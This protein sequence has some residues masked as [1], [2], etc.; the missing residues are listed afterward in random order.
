MKDAAHWSLALLDRRVGQDFPSHPFP[1][2]GQGRMLQVRGCGSSDDFDA[3]RAIS[4]LTGAFPR[5]FPLF[6]WCKDALRL[7]GSDFLGFL[8]EMKPCFL[9]LARASCRVHQGCVGGCAPVIAL[10]TS[11]QRC[12]FR[13]ERLGKDFL[14]PFSCEGSS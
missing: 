9:C 6:L 13:K 10:N 11:A 5:L 12:N 7:F 4:I 3:G 1:W 8:L 2:E 14:L